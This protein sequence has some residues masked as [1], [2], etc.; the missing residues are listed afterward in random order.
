MIEQEK[1][2]EIIEKTDIVSLVSQY[3]QLS[4]AGSDF[5]GLCPFHNE[6]TPSFMVSPSK[7]IAKCMGCG[8]GGNPITFLKEVKNISFE[9]ACIE[10]ASKANVELNIKKKDT[11]PDLSKYYKIMEEAA[12]F[13]HYNLIS[14][15]SGQEA[16]KYLLNRGLTLD[17]INE[18][19]IGLAPSKNDALYLTL[20]DLGYNEIDMID[21]GL[22][23]ESER[24]KSFFDLFKTRIMFPVTDKDSNI[25][26]FSG[27][28]YNG[29]T[30]QAKYINSPETI[31]FKKNMSIYHLDQARPFILKNKRVILHEG[32]MDVIASTRSGL[33]EA[34]CSM[35]TALTSNQVKLL[36]SFT[37][38]IIVCYDGDS[39]G[40]N[41]MVKAIKLLKAENFNISLVRLPDGLDPDEYVLKFGSEKYNDYFNSH[42]EDPNDYLYEYVTQ[43]LKK[44]SL[45][46]IEIVKNKLFAYLKNLNS[47]SL[48]E[49]YLHRFS[50]TTGVSFASLILDYNAF[51]NQSGFIVKQDV[52]A[53]N[54]ARTDALTNQFNDKD[55]QQMLSRQKAEL[56]IFVYAMMSKKIALELDQKRLGNIILAQ[57]FD[58]AHINLWESLINDYY[59]S[60]DEYNEGIFLKFLNE[61]EYNCLVSDKSTL[62]N[63]NDK[64]EYT[65]KDLNL[66]VNVLFSTYHLKQVINIENDFSNIMSNEEKLEAL[67]RKQKHLMEM[68]KH[69]N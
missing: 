16:I 42:I 24:N 23:K 39:A 2:N 28:I 55:W 9:D 61:N 59:I 33:G 20:K 60:Y 48:V 53:S 63:L 12:K 29:E 54:I 35:G 22:I 46:Q 45:D 4:K 64:T 34:V 37:D 50:D 62:K 47:R 57:T 14:T 5:K 7:K 68:K 66:C 17:I 69:I 58:Q 43:G 21:C 40:I 25:V 19:N 41:A 8:K 31:I 27:R 38:N 13:Y 10:L 67:S 26:A 15:K 1:I 11:G 49:G 56:R 18:F 30:D 44:G 36:K 32:Q 6:K 3:V 51:I 65:K 52:N